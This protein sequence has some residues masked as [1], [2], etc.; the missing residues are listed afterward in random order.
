MPHVE[1]LI[2]SPSDLKFL[3]DSKL[4]AGLKNADITVAVSACSAHRN[5]AELTERINA[6]IGK[7]NAF[8]CAA[9]WSAALPGAVKAKLLGRSLATVFGVALPSDA[10]PDAADALMSIK[11]LPP[12]IDVICPEDVGS[13]GFDNILYQVVDAAQSYDPT[14]PDQS[15]LE[16][17]RAKIKQPQ[18]D[19]NLEED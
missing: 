9:G 7:T 4:V 17:V 10:Y 12:G 1:V 8:V 6:V 11:R 16:A 13:A 15:Q 19:I 3:K 18:F 14:S 2:G 5:D